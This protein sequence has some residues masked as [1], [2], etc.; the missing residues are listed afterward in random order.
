MKV[1]EVIGQRV[2][3][4]GDQVAFAT[5]SHD[6]NPLHMDSV[7]ARRLVSGGQV[8]HGINILLTALEFAAEKNL[9][10]GKISRVRSEFKIT[11]NLGE[12]VFFSLLE[13]S[14]EQA[15][16]I[17]SLGEVVC[18]RMIVSF[19]DELSD[20]SPIL[21]MHRDSISVGASLTPMALSQQQYQ[22]YAADLVWAA[23]K[24]VK[25][26]DLYPHLA[27]HC[28][29]NLCHA[30]AMLSYIVGM[31]CPGLNSVFVSLDV[32][33]MA[34]WQDMT[35]TGFHV[36]KFEDRVKLLEL[37]VDDGPLR[38]TIKA[39][40][41][42]EPVGQPGIAKVMDSVS[43]GEFADLDAY[44]IGGSR[45]LGELVG[46]IIAAGGG[47][48]T[49][50]YVLGKADATHVCDEV[51][52]ALPGSCS[53]DQFDISSA[54]IDE[55]AAMLAE[56]NAIFY[57]ATPVIS[58]KINTV[59]DPEVFRRLLDFYV[60]SFFRLCAALEKHAKH[61]ISV[62]YPS[63]VF[64]AER[65]NGMTEYAMAKSAAELMINDMNRAFRRVRIHV[66][67][68]PRLRSDQTN[69][70]FPVKTEDNLDHML[71]VVRYVA[72]S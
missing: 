7:K 4:H 23:E 65:P 38:G 46:K 60:Y 41:R 30:F 5:L 2:F 55:K 31:V 54:D 39:F 50:S 32:A 25:A 24:T 61:K 16:I 45:G 47:H 36:A 72:T 53:I 43:A 51:N 44:V 9:L 21:G 8:V 19:G 68:L 59:F 15:V 1:P 67:R 14:A 29:A 6:W 62:F 52:A 63:T 27:E 66:A 26:A 71:K 11:V 70:V 64:V 57:F 58:K 34:G 18:T 42:P 17:A 12:E 3:T 48:A 69:S 10:P 13:L 33:F 40:Y 20:Q 49:L 35:H 37:A 22:G 56:R 28:N